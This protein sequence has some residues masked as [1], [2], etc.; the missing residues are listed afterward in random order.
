MTLLWVPMI[1]WGVMDILV[2][3]LINLEG[4]GVKN[5]NESLSDNG[6]NDV[7]PVA[8]YGD[9]HLN[10]CGGGNLSNF[11]LQNLCQDVNALEN[12]SQ[13]NMISCDSSELIMDSHRAFDIN[14]HFTS[15]HGSRPGLMIAH[16]EAFF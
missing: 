11:I 1:S 12:V 13:L 8:V 16:M 4:V 10:S 3:N 2:S 14:T 7:M 5:K 9:I 6:I 15:Q